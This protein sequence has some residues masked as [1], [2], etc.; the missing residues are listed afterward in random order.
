MATSVGCAAVLFDGRTKSFVITK[1]S[2][3]KSKYPRHWELPGGTLNDGED[4]EICIRREIKEE[5]NTEIANLTLAF[6]DCAYHDDKRYI[7][8]V[9]LGEINTAS[10]RIE[11]QEIETIMRLSLDDTLPTPLYPRVKEQLLR[12]SSSSLRVIA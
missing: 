9:Y 11:P 12:V 8:F 1:R 5:L 3:N 6:V 10:I 7:V 2:L 4:P